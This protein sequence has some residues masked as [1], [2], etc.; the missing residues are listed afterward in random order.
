MQKKIGIMRLK[1]FNTTLTIIALAIIIGIVFQDN[2]HLAF[3]IVISL[4]GL[5]ILIGFL[6]LF[7]FKKLA[8]GGVFLMAFC[9]GVLTYTIHYQPNKKNHYIQKLQPN[10][11]YILEG[12][13]I[14]IKGKKAIID[15]Q[16]SDNHKVTGKVQ[17]SFSDTLSI[18]NLGNSLL[19]C[20]KLNPIPK[21]KNPYQFDYQ[22]Y[23]SRQNIFWTGNVTDFQ[24]FPTTD[25][26]LKI[27]ASHLQNKI[28]SSLS[29]YSAGRPR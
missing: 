18:E 28:A 22:K 10:Q 7:R 1:P 24:I 26:S 3:S 13:I 20:T 8:F 6:L 21:A 17:L 29:K 27:F 2:F 5:S 23:M 11:F 12:K 14:E 4:M 9:L 19:F 15:L 16:N 25:F